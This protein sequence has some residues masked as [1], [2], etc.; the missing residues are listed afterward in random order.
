MHDPQTLNWAGITFC[1]VMTLLV[2]TSVVFSD[3]IRRWAESP[4]PTPAPRS[5]RIDSANYQTPEHIHQIDFDR[6]QIM[7]RP[8]GSVMAG[9]CIQGC[10]LVAVIGRQLARA[11][12]VEDGRMS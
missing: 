12:I 1:V 4:D 10:S 7:V 6:S 5:E 9:C 8:D 3:R 2:I 11:T